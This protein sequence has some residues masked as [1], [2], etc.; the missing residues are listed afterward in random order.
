MKK[1]QINSYQ[2]LLKS[3]ENIAWYWN[4]VNEDLGLEWYDDYTQVFDSSEGFPRTKWFVNDKCNI[5]YNAVDKH[6]T[7]VLTRLHIFSKLIR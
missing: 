1:H 7:V 3:V 2:Q 5:V 4:A 6:A